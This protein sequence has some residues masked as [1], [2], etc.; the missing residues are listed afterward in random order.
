ML[1]GR[2][3]TLSAH[4]SDMPT[5]RPE[6]G[7]HN[8][9]VAGHPPTI[10]GMVDGVVDALIEF[11]ESIGRPQT[12]LKFFTSNDLPGFFEKDLEHLQWLVLESDAQ[13]VLAQFAYAGV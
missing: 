10:P 8:F 6:R 7:W 12:A 1:L 13:A 4:F 11:N 2:K 9:R 5:A 3:E